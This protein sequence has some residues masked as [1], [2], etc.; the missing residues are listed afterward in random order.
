MNKLLF[1][2]F[3]LVMPAYAAEDVDCGT[4]CQPGQ[5]LVTFADGDSATCVCVTEGT[6]EETVEDPNTP[7][8]DWNENGTQTQE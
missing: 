4:S 2:S 7:A 6:M 3:L 8:S 5:K 1:L